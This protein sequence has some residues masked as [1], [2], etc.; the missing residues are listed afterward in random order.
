MKIDLDIFKNYEIEFEQGDLVW[1]K[2]GKKMLSCMIYITDTFEIY[3]KFE[4]EKKVI[5]HLDFILHYN[6]SKYCIVNIINNFKETNP[7]TEI[8]FDEKLLSYYHPKINKT[9]GVKGDFSVVKAFY[10]GIKKN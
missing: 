4:S 3:V 8:E 9:I 5:E 6:N 2:D 7:Y 10:E 1:R